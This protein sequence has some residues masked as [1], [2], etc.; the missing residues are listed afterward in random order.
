[1]FK[2]RKEEARPADQ[3]S[4]HQILAKSLHSGWKLDKYSDFGKFLNR[5]TIKSW[6]IAV[7]VEFDSSR[8]VVYQAA[9]VDADSRETLFN[10]KI[11]GATGPYHVGRPINFSEAALKLFSHRH[12]TYNFTRLTG[13]DVKTKHAAAARISQSGIKPTDIILVW[14]TGYT[15]ARMIRALLV[16]QG[17]ED[18]MPPNHRIIRLNYLFHHNLHELP[19]N[20][21]EVVYPTILPQHSLR[22][23]SHDALYDSLKT[24][25]MAH[26]AERFLNSKSMTRRG[27]LDHLIRGLDNDA[28]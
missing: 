2:A 25:D 16:K 23:Y 11:S 9:A 5:T 6:V 21:L 8:D 22:Y 24:M 28:L 10:L 20:A 13:D 19:T 27:T 17:F 14:Q 7:D 4:I 18:I 12:W 3:D 26:E 15:D 1:M